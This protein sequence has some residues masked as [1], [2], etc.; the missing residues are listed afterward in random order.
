MLQGGDFQNGDGSGGA[1]IYGG[2]FDDENFLLKHETGGLVSVLSNMLSINFVLALDGELRPK[3]QWI[4]VFHHNS[5]LPSPRW[6]TRCF[7]PSMQP[8]I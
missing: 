5:E 6:K 1:S 7:W 3:H 8:I 4:P 2:K